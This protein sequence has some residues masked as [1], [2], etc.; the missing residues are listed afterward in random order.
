MHS[1]L[2]R[3]PNIGQHVIH[4]DGFLGADDSAYEGILRHG[5][6]HRPNGWGVDESVMWGDY[7][8]M[9]ALYTVLQEKV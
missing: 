4:V 3:R 6:Y 1:Q 5:V 9:E 7:F 8:F 2:R